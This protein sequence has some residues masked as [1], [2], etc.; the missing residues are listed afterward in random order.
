MTVMGIGT[1]WTKLPRLPLVPGPRHPLPLDLIWFQNAHSKLTTRPHARP[2]ILLAYGVS[3]VGSGRVFVF[4]LVYM[5]SLVGVC[6]L[7]LE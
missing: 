5:H 7:E 1:N 2:R 4:V 3:L 6:W